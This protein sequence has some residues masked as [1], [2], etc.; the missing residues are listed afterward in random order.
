MTQ[1]VRMEVHVVHQTLVSVQQDILVTTVKQVNSDFIVELFII[2]SFSCLAVCD[3]DCEN[4]GTC[5]AP[6]TCICA[7]GYT[8]DHCQTGAF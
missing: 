8:G 3:T 4:G 5:S 6:N 7:T 1:I 2:F